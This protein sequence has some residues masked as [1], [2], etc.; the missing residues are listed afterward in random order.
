MRGRIYATLSKRKITERI[1][2]FNG[3][4]GMFRGIAAASILIAICG[5]IQT[6][7]KS[8]Q[9]WIPLIISLPAI[10]RCYRFGVYYA[11]ELYWVALNEGSKQEEVAK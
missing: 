3:N 4:Y 6:D 2:I 9:F 5:F 10:Y 1:D 7:L 8:R 11:K